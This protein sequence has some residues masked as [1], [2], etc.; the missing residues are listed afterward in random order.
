MVNKNI[1]FLGIGGIGMSAL[2]RY[3][4]MQ[5][6]K[7]SGYDKTR[8]ELT[9]SLENEGIAIHY[10]DLGKAAIKDIDLVVYT[11]AIPSELREYIEFQK[12][13]IRM[14]KR[15]EILGEITKDY[16]TI[17]VAGTHGKTTITSMIAH[18][19]NE[20]GIAVNAFIGGIATNYNSNLILNSKAKIMVVEA[21]E[22]DRSF[23][24]IHPDIAIISSM[25]ADHLD[26]YDNKDSLKASFYEFANNIKAGG[27]LLL[28]DRLE[29]P[30][31]FKEKITFYGEEDRSSNKLKAIG[32]ENEKQKFSVSNY[33]GTFEISMAGRHNL[34]N[35][36]AAISVAK[37]LEVEFKKLNK[38][39][40]NYK[41][42]KRRFELITKCD[43]HILIDDYAHHPTEIKA[44]IAATKEM[45]VGKEI[46]GIFQ[47]HLYSRTRDFAKDFAKELSELDQLVLKMIAAKFSR[48]DT[49]FK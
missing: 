19:L 39:V 34:L 3:F 49:M 14:V 37:L 45:Y 48:E 17:A 15:A 41:G 33:N 8:T 26:I 44:A 47:P 18:F 12:S 31:N 22:F 29:A 46:T 27:T 23:L 42:V 35:A 5:G 21:D 13:E 7:V 20:S 1:Y 36:T 4:N 6:N 9:I 30:N 43:K 25:D 11:P 38:S 28:H 10:N 40:A 2:A 32:I 24:H 16:F